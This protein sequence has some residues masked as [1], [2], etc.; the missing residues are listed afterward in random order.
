VAVVED[1]RTDGVTA[2]GFGVPS[3]VDSR[4]GRIRYSVNVPLVD[5]PLRDLLQDRLGLPVFVE[6]DANCAA[7]AEAYEGEHLTTR[8]LVMITLGTGVGGG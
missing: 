6:N 3:I 1:V 8:E 7:L 4:T 5:L 2:V